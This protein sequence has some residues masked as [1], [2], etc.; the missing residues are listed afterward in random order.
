MEWVNVFIF[1]SKVHAGDSNSVDI[2]VDELQTSPGKRTDELV[3]DLSCQEIS[4]L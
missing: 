3:K 4:S 1:G 2:F